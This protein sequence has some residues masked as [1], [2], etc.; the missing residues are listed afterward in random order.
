MCRIWIDGVPA[1]QQP[2]PTDCPTALKNRPANGRVLFGDEFTDSSKTKGDDKPKLPPSAKG[3]T[4]V[5]PGVRIL[6]K[7]PPG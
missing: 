1:N 4:E 3:F 5:K 2:A 7:R 6:P